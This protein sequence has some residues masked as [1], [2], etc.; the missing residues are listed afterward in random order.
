MAIS[1]AEILRELIPGLQAL[2]GSEYAP[3]AEFSQY[4]KRLRPDGY[5]IYRWDFS[6]GKKVSST[7]LARGLSKDAAI[8]MMK[9]LAEPKCTVEPK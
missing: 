1:R 4:V 8:G 7:T 2:F 9:L 3:Y 6:C 5:R